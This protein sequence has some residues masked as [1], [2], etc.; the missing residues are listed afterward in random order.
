M[1]VK[2][3]SSA[4]TTGQNSTKPPGFSLAELLAVIAVVS[5]LA[6]LVVGTL[7]KVR[8]KAKETTCLNNLEQIYKV[9]LLYQGDNDERFP[10]STSGCLWSQR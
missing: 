3:Q 8:Q 6:A 1:A 7:F 5:V 10:P 4:E 2:Q 9:I